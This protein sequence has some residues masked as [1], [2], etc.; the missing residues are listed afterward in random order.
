MSV[1]V[2]DVARAPPPELLTAP[3]FVSAVPAQRMLSICFFARFASA[4]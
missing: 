3:G 2:V 1:V 4:W